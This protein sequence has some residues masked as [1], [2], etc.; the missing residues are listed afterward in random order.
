M[1]FF[2][3]KLSKNCTYNSPAMPGSAFSKKLKKIRKALDS[4]YEVPA[5]VFPN[6]PEIVPIISFIGLS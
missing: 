4:G 2:P 1:N 6:A 3:G 5:L